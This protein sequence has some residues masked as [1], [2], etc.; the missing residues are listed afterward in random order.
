MERAA[1]KNRC[2]EILHLFLLQKHGTVALKIPIAAHF[3]NR[4]TENFNIFSYFPKEDLQCISNLLFETSKHN[5]FLEKQAFS[6]MF[7]LYNILRELKGGTELS[8][9]M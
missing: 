2:L 6:G 4:E 1:L 8:A 7:L 3:E 5:T 9:R